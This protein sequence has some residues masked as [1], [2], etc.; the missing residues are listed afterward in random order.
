MLDERFGLKE[1]VTTSL[2]LAPGQE[3]TPAGQALLADVNERLGNLDVGSGFPVR[4]PWLTS[5]APTLAAALAVAAFY[6][7]PPQ[8]QATSGNEDKL[9][10]VPPN[11]KEIEQKLQQLKK[12]PTEKKPRERALSA[13]L[14]RI[15]AELDQIANRP[16][17]TKEQLKER[18][19]EMTAL[20]DQLKNREKDMAER[21]KSL[22]QQLK[23]LDR[24]ADKS[25]NQDGPAKDLQKALSD[26]KLDKAKE[27]LEHLSKKLKAGELTRKEKEQLARQLKDLQ[28]KLQRA[29][30][31]KD[32]EDHLRQLNKEGKL[33]QEAL[34]RE[35]DRLKEEGQKLKDLKG[36]AS[37]LGQVRKGLQQGDGTAAAEAL[38]AA[39]NQVKD[40][41]LAEGDLQDLREQ[42]QAL[43]NAKDS[44]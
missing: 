20:E 41:E 3:M 5:L 2:T 18:I 23:Q 34:N 8:S 40:M 1:R 30:Q 44:C 21:A 14:K 29:A 35:L 19:K 25:G 6:Y 4:V 22:Q 38:D 43:Q 9:A 12:K 16:R 13:E 26:G 27:E 17:A 7:E 42:L 37:Q 33:T 39:A 31:H 36:L 28:E 24:T 32:K 15:E 11:A 10:Q